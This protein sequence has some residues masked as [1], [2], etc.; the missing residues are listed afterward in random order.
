MKHL[1]FL[2]AIG[3]SSASFGQGEL[4]SKSKLESWIRVQLDVQDNMPDPVA[5]GQRMIDELGISNDDV[6][7]VST[8]DPKTLSTADQVIYKN[9]KDAYQKEVDKEITKQGYKYGMDIHTYYQIKYY[10]EQDPRFED[11][12]KDLTKKIVAQRSLSPR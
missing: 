11:V 5:F 10:Y 6:A 7:R 8:D 9:I 3:L 12:V 2:L 4:V 1:V